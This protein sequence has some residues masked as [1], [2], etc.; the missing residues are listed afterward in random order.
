[1]RK[2]TG[3]RVLGL[4][5][6]TLLVVGLAI[7][8]TR[9]P[10]PVH[11]V[12]EARPRTK[13]QPGLEIVDARLRGGSSQRTSAKV[14]YTV[15]WTTSTFPG[16]FRCTWEALS[17]E[18]SIVGSYTTEVISLQPSAQ[19]SQEIPISGSAESAAGACD[20]ERL[21]TGGEYRY[22]IN[23]VKVSEM[24]GSAVGV[25]FTPTWMGTGWPGVVTCSAEGRA[26]DSVVAT[27]TF[28]FASGVKQAPPVDQR[29]E[30][31]D[32]VTADAITSAAVDCLPFE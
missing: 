26:G 8:A 28:N 4:G 10:S 18:G 7:A 1:M 11:R 29:I 12:V 15:R 13:V 14:E 17:N 21:D 23:D 24:S 5:V 9:V 30:L 2:R 16:V 20:E 32:G 6:T 22:E 19:S 25:T 3:T 27:A 31:P